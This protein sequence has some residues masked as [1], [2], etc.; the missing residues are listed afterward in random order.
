MS[1]EMVK[2][3]LIIRM[4]IM[5]ILFSG[6]IYIHK[7]NVDPIWKFGYFEIFGIARTT[8]I[9]IRDVGY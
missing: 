5:G 8:P 1:I 2:R 9:V 7:T 4:Y 6:V 3:V